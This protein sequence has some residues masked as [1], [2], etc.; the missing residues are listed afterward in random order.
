MAHYKLIEQCKKYIQKGKADKLHEYLKQNNLTEEFIRQIFN[1]TF[2]KS[3][4]GKE[5]EEAL[6]ISNF[7]LKISMESLKERFGER[8]A[9]R[10]TEIMYNMPQPSQ[11]NFNLFRLMNSPIQSVTE[12]QAHNIEKIL[13]ISSDKNNI[14]GTH[15]IGAELGDKLASEGILLTGHKFAVKD[16]STSIKQKIEKN[17]T[18]YQND[19][20]GVI[21][22]M[23]EGREYNR[24]TGQFNDIMIVS[25]PREELERNEQGII[26]EKDQNQYVN[27]AYIKGFARIGVK[28]A[29]FEKFLEN[30]SFIEKSQNRQSTSSDE[31]KQ[32]FEQW[33][34]KS[35]TTKM[36]KMK[37]GITS[38]I[39]KILNKEKTPRISEQTTEIEK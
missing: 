26:I 9:D 4:K 29:N 13:D 8:L 18:L 36:Q 38:F 28:N 35:T 27:P 10:F 15:F 31:W 6:E 16:D 25:I 24:Q 2:Q 11:R 22:Q 32:K 1:S 12:E 23:I 37:L 17:V 30:P 39:K 34:E 3:Y 5:Y 14:I 33:Y 21:L 19:P 20:L 7:A